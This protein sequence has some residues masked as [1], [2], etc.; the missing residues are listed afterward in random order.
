M[1]AYTRAVQTMSR[2]GM[3]EERRAD[4]D[5]PESPQRIAT[6]ETR[7]T[8]ARSPPT[9]RARVRRRR[10]ANARRCADRDCRLTG[11][12]A[13][14]VGA[15]GEPGLGVALR[16]PAPPADLEHLVEVEL[17]DGDDDVEPRDQENR[18]AVDED[19]RSSCPGAIVEAVVPLVEQ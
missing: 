1:V 19:G 15:V 7:V 8:T 17:V 16:Q 11:A 5:G 2:A 6:K 9:A 4:R 10:A 13:S 12:A 3:T 14:E 18:T